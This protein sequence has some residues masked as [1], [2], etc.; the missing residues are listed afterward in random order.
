MIETLPIEIL[1]QIVFH[2]SAARDVV[3]LSRT[4]RALYVKLSADDYAIF[5]L[6]VQSH[7]PSIQTPPLWREA[8]CALTSRSRAWD[9][10]AFVARECLPPR[11][12]R[13]SLPAEGFA[14]NP[15]T[16]FGYVPVIDSYETWDGGRW[17]D[18]REV[19]AWGAA[20]R[21][22]T[23]TTVNGSVAWRSWP[24][25][26]D[27]L[28]Q[29]DILDIRLLRP[30]QR[31]STQVE[32]VVLRRANGEI[33]KVTFTPDDS[34]FVPISSYASDADGVDCMDI[35]SA[36]QPCLAVC[37]PNSIRIFDVNSS[38]SQ[39][40]P[41]T[42]HRL[43]P[44]TVFRRRMRCAR[45]LDERT[46][47]VA[48]QY[49]EG[50]SPAP[51]EVYDLGPAGLHGGGR[52]PALSIH[53]I[54][55]DAK[56]KISATTLV[57]LEAVNSLAGRQGEVFL[58]G[59]T[60]GVIRLYDRRAPFMPRSSYFDA[61][62]DGHILSLLPIGHERVLAGSHQNACL[63]TFDLRMPGGRR[64]S[65]LDAAIRQRES[66]PT[67]NHSVLSND[68]TSRVLDPTAVR[69]NINIFVAPKVYQNERLWQPL[70]RRQDRPLPRYRGSIYSLSAPSPT[71]STVY[72]GVENHV[73]QLDFVSTDDVLSSKQA[74]IRNGAWLPKSAWPHVLDLSCYEQPR[75][76]EYAYTDAILLRKQRPF[77]QTAT[78]F[79]RRA[80]SSREDGWD[81]RWEMPA[82]GNGS[83]RRSGR[84][85]R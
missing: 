66:I 24:T 33:I 48:V 69:R 83:S 27:H 8:A 81:S 59:W 70:P 49:L 29:T 30:H 80:K 77:F 13:D 61:V 85:E 75:E 65:Y 71:S 22:R 74:F 18:R 76:G 25:A 57:A 12:D 14:H 39:I 56:E 9:R 53:G 6:F 50:R 63:K 7:F 84:W 31:Q 10:R 34:R 64:Y 44:A 82:V 2:L 38:G 72:V 23:R 26:N 79:H 36:P 21:L 78:D 51:I 20:G 58:S 62:D 46:L 37:N 17:S 42:A 11:D 55:S 15:S 35:S 4:S 60:D 54:D 47:A 67:S 73:V 5:R 40:Q 19:L 32:N 28:A 41:K 3:N 43:Q 16:S 68:L 45:F 1:E 52:A